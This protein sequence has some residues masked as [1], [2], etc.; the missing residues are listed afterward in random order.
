[1]NTKE[2]GIKK[3]Q[4]LAQR[5]RLFF[6]SCGKPVKKKTEAVKKSS[7]YRQTEKKTM[8]SY[9]L[10]TILDISSR[11]LCMAICWRLVSHRQTK[12]TN[13]RLNER[14]R[15]KNARALA[16]EIGDELTDLLDVCFY[17]KRFLFAFI[18]L[19]WLQTEG[20]PWFR[21]F[22]DAEDFFSPRFLLNYFFFRCFETRNVQNAIKW[23]YNETNSIL[24]WWVKNVNDKKKKKRRRARDRENCDF[25]IIFVVAKLNRIKS[26]NCAVISS[27]KREWNE[28]KC[29][30]KTDFTV[31][32]FDLCQWKRWHLCMR[33]CNTFGIL[34]ERAKKKNQ[35]V[36]Q[37]HIIS[38]ASQVNVITWHSNITFKTHS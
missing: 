22:A 1:M 36:R 35:I 21:C 37:F 26:F 25:G 10:I 31:W 3:K 20:G 15:H 38:K 19:P 28:K 11:G 27:R 34:N 18:C 30:T 9:K 2:S 8:Q 16:T 24:K 32:K 33:Y 5:M 12:W 17:C 29:Y 13:E 14:K 7:A 23:N 4:S 6:G